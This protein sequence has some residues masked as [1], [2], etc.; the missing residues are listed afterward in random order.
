[1]S[2]YFA[3]IVGRTLWS[4]VLLIGL[5]VAIAWLLQRIGDRIR[6]IGLLTCALDYRC[7][8]A[9]WYFVAIGVACHETGHAVGTWITG[10]KVL[11][12][13]PFALNRKDGPPNA[14]GWVSH[15]VGS[16]VWGKVSQVIISTGPIWFGS[17]VILL[18]TRFLVGQEMNISYY[19]YFTKGELPGLFVYLVACLRCVA[20]LCCDLAGGALV[21][22][23][24]MFLWAYLVFCIASEIGM[25]DIDMKNAR[26]GF[27]VMFGIALA[28]LLLPVTGK[29][30]A[31]G[32]AF[33]LPKF[34]IVHV[35]M[36]LAVFIN[37]GF[38][39]LERFIT[40]II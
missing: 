35:L 4:G 32:V 14:I 10:N 9:Y 13:V 30:I 5:P 7:G 18:L 31:A 11:E 8:R 15:T 19:D 28:L 39:F 36:I 2:D 22:G 12:F 37:T 34:F 20:L 40:R 25:S 24:K 17:F 33:L 6:T 26:A 27:A 23:W 16:G 21:S 1:M 3:N 29:W 38:L